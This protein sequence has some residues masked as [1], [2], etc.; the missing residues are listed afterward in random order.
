MPPKRIMP[1]A[2]SGLIPILS[3]NIAEPSHMAAMTINFINI[4]I[5]CPNSTYYAYFISSDP[6]SHS[7]AG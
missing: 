1:G 7:G 5:S 4:I 2:T 6:V 3:D